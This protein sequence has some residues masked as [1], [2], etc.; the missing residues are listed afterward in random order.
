MI[1]YK[2]G[3]YASIS[4]NIGQVVATWT[5]AVPSGWRTCRQT[6]TVRGWLAQ[7]AVWRP[8]STRQT[9]PDWAPDVALVV[10]RIEIGLVAGAGEPLR[11]AAVAGGGV[12]VVA[13]AAAG[14]AH[15]V[16]P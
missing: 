16:F 10:V 3:L 7:P 11:A 4:S 13:A 12:T 14:L 15:V 6:V 2:L 5:R 9:S 8:R 1:I